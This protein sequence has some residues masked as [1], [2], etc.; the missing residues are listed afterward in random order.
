ML[1][2]KLL[3]THLSRRE[4]QIM[5][6]IYALGEATAAEVLDQL[7]DPP[8]NASVRATLRTLEE[9]GYLK[10]RKEGR[11]F[12][13]S[14]A[15]S[16]EVAKRS[17]FRNIVNVFF[18]GSTPKTVTAML[19]MSADELSNEDLDELSEFIEQAKRKRSNT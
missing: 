3:H 18:G 15:I 19:N 4:S 8:R 10:H 16:P 5:D 7:L 12:V 14:P 9:K 17:M 1:M 2:K 13:Y 11:S 6:I